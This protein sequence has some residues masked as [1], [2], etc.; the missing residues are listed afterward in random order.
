MILIITYDLKTPR[1]YHDFYETLKA[2]ADPGK[3]WHFM[4]STW[5]ISTRK[6][7]QQVVEALRQDK[8]LDPAD[9]I[10]VCELFPNY[11]GWLPKPAWDWLRDELG[12]PQSAYNYLNALGALSGGPTNPPS[13]NPFLPTDP[14]S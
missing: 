1:D 12:Q 4:A 9:T 13:R 14:S 5:I 8:Y 7:P 3:W 11:Q 2:Q 10:F 6:T